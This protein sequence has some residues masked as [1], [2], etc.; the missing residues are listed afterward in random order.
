MEERNHIK[1]VIA[2]EVYELTSSESPEHVQNVAAYIDNK[3]TEIYS[4]KSF[5]YINHRLKTL[6]VS[7]NIA[8]DLFKEKEKVRTLEL[9]KNDLK[10]KLDSCMEENARLSEDNKL[11]LENM[12]YLQEELSKAKRELVE[13][14]DNFEN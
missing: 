6:F 12:T 11:L 5:G 9:E 14:I 13:Y 2:G 7:L 8:D 1:V 10:V 3:L 4:K